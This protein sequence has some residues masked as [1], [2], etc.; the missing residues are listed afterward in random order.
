MKET[1]SGTLN[2]TL[3]WLGQG[4]AE[5]LSGYTHTHTHESSAVQTDV[6]V[7]SAC[8]GDHIFNYNL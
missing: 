6:V 1:D 5:G 8:K 7:E 4:A 2:N 3:I